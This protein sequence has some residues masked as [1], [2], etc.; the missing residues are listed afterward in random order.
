MRKS[1]FKLH[2]L[3]SRYAGYIADTTPCFEV[4]EA[5]DIVREYN[6]NHKYQI[7]YSDAN[8]CFWQ[9]DLSTQKINTWKGR[10]YQTA[11]GIKHLY[12]IGDESWKWKEELKCTDNTKTHTN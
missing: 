7:Y 11:E 2:Y 12:R 1:M 6:K 10:N 8:D 3:P 5:M 4:G 9:P